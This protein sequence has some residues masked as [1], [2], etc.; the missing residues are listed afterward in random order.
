MYKVS[1]SSDSFILLVYI[2]IFFSFNYHIIIIIIFFIYLFILQLFLLFLN[3][4]L[5]YLSNLSNFVCGYIYIFCLPF[6]VIAQGNI[7]LH[8]EYDNNF[9]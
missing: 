4:Q 5:V 8:C 2:Y 1:S 3:H 7:F 6:V 9:L